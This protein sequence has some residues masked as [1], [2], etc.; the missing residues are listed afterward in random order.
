MITSRGTQWL[1]IIIH[2]IIIHPPSSFTTCVANQNAIHDLPSSSSSFGRAV[3]ISVIRSIMRHLVWVGAV[4]YSVS[5]KRERDNLWMWNKLIYCVKI[6][7]IGAQSSIVRFICITSKPP[8]WLII[9]YDIMMSSQIII[10]HHL[11]TCTTRR[12]IKDSSPSMAR[13]IIY[14]FILT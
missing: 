7:E 1:I 5:V 6:A 3:I 2:L 8:N 9:D 4:N 11:H 10:S 14:I 13:P 12:V